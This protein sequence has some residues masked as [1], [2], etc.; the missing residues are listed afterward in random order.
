VNL[1]LPGFTTFY[2]ALLHGDISGI[3]NTGA[4]DMW[5]IIKTTVINSNTVFR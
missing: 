1:T 4:A 5:A 2:D 3:D